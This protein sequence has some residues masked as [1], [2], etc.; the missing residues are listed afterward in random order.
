MCKRRHNQGRTIGNYVA[1]LMVMLFFGCLL[2]A[3]GCEHEWSDATCLAPKTCRLCNITE[4]KALG[5]DYDAATCSTAKTCKRCRSVAGDPLGHDYGEADCSN[6]QMCLRCDATKGEPLGHT[7]NAGYC[8]RC[9][10]KDPYF[11]DAENYGFINNFGKYTWVEITAYKI[12]TNNA[13]AKYEESRKAHRIYAFRDGVMYEYSRYET[14]HGDETRKEA[15]HKNPTQTLVYTASYSVINN[16]AINIDGDTWAIFER[17]FDKY[18]HLVI[19]MMEGSEERWYILAEQIDWTQSPGIE[20]KGYSD[21][22]I[23]T[24]YWK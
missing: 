5:H 10:E 6:P 14:P 16:D 11:F 3:C 19:K 17:K 15:D 22:K 8:D 23:F 18:G 21:W 1:V 7:F 13:Y 2:T 4:G 9:F 12:G 20:D 24:Y